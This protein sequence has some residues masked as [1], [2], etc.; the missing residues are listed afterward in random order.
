MSKKLNFHDVTQALLSAWNDTC[1]DALAGPEDVYAGVSDRLSPK[2]RLGIVWIDGDDPLEWRMQTLHYASGMSTF[3]D[4]RAV[5]RDGPLRT[6]QEPSYT[7]AFMLPSLRTC[8][9]TKT[10]II[11]SLTSRPLDL[12]LFYDRILLPQKSVARPE[13]I[14]SVADGISVLQNPQSPTSLGFED[15]FI[16]QRLIEGQTAKEIA[17]ALE[18]SHR[19][20][21]HRIGLLKDRLKAKNV[22]HLTSMFIAENLSR[23]LASV[24]L[25]REGARF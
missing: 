10:P 4:D 11:E 18:L 20:V 9:M 8:A 19:T 17:R 23:A 25:L 7:E 13:W 5:F 6:F 12:T 14:I 21:E 22:T 15:N 3:F 16:V 1:A 24:T 2:M